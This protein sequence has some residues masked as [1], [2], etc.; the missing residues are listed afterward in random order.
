MATLK[1]KN[2]KLLHMVAEID[3]MSRQELADSGN[4]V[5]SYIALETPQ[6]CTVSHLKDVALDVLKKK[7]GIHVHDVLF[8]LI[9][10]KDVKKTRGMVRYEHLSK[11]ELTS[12]R[13]IYKHRKLSAHLVL[14]S[15][16]D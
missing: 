9:D 8:T 15:D 4:T 14:R 16:S 5:P 11:Y 3:E 7:H 10:S 2:V 13:A 1:Y 6:D 12:R